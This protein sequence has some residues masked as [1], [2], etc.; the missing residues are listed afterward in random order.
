MKINFVDMLDYRSIKAVFR[1]HQLGMIIV[2]LVYFA[3]LSKI[4]STM[5]EHIH[6]KNLEQFQQLYVRGE[7]AKITGKP[8]CDISKCEC[9]KDMSDYPMCLL[10]NK[11]LNYVTQGKCYGTGTCESKIRGT[12]AN[13]LCEY[14]CRPADEIVYTIRFSETPVQGDIWSTWSNETIRKSFVRQNGFRSGELSQ[15]QTNLLS[16]LKRP[17]RVWIPREGART[18]HWTMPVKD[19]IFVVLVL[20]LISLGL[21]II[22]SYIVA[23]WMNHI[24]HLTKRKTQKIFADPNDSILHMV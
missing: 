3:F 24:Y 21:M 7:I 5:I 8:L 10:I 18:I 17:V 9:A 14:I 15:L 11:D 4:N 6:A 13:D 2:T 20:T 23:L 22:C 1:L 19:G 16:T 12:V